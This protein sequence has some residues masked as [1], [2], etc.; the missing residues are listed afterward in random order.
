[1][2]IKRVRQN[3]ATLRELRDLASELFISINEFKTRVKNNPDHRLGNQG[4]L[5]LPHY[6]MSDN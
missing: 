6:L 2:T 1:M 3:R 5:R 4:F